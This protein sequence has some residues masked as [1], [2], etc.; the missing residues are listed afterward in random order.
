[1]GEVVL[2]LRKGVED[3]SELKPEFPE[4]GLDTMLSINIVQRTNF[5]MVDPKTDG[6]SVNNSRKVGTADAKEK[7]SRF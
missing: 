4:A 5:K 2:Y 3:V 7:P 6:K 1:V